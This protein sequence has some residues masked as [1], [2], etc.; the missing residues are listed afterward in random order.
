M[1][2]T[3]DIQYFSASG[4]WVKPA[5]AVRVDIMLKA[6]DGAGVIPLIGTLPVAGEAGEL[7]ARSFAADD[8]PG[9]ITVTAGAGSGDGRDGYALVVTHLR[10]GQGAPARVGYRAGGAT[11]GPG[12]SRGYG[13]AGGGG[14]TAFPYATG[15]NGSVSTAAA[16]RGDGQARSSR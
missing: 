8:L 16:G 15:G 2:G 12:V 5:G 10:V 6:A 14:S 13:G 1:S 9:R 7:I 11:G 3:P 4:T